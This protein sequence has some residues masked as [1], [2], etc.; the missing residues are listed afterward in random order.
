MTVYYIYYFVT[1]IFMKSICVIHESSSES[2]GLRRCKIES[3]RVRYQPRG[4]AW[5]CGRSTDTDENTY[6]R[7][8]GLKPQDSTSA[9]G[10][11]PTATCKLSSVPDIL[12]T[13]PPTH[14]KKT[15]Y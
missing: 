3:W 5:V 4:E 2:K 8:G 1:V 6:G 10:D 7:S 15:V 14:P 9:H 13:L 12:S 11:E